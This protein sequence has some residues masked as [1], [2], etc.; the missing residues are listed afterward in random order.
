MGN[1]PRR[2]YIF[3]RPVQEDDA[4]SNGSQPD[5]TDAP[6]LWEDQPQYNS[7]DYPENY[8][9]QG[10]GLL[11]MLLRG[12]QQDR[13]QPTVDSRLASNFVPEINSD[14][15]GNPQSDSIGRLAAMQAK[16][17]PAQPSIARDQLPLS[18]PR[19]PNFRQL[20]RAPLAIGAP[21]MSGGGLGAYGEKP[22]ASIATVPTIKTAQLVLPGGRLPFPSI[23][24]SPP[25]PIPMPPIPFAWKVIGGVA[26]MLPRVA[27]GLAGRG[28]DGGTAGSPGGATILDQRKSPGSGSRK[29]G[30][31]SS[32]DDDDEPE[33]DPDKAIED[34]RKRIAAAA[35]ERGK[36][37]S[38]NRNRTGY[39][40]RDYCDDRLEDEMRECYK[41]WSQGEMAEESFLNACIEFAR[42]RRNKC[43][44]GDLDPEGFD[45]WNL[46]REEVYNRDF[47][48][49][50]PSSD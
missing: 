41:R 46:E 28:D 47:L 35:R 27:S 15:F 45:E 18:D 7:S 5:T 40:L 4:D 20:S 36:A 25:H 34:N 32:R 16:P 44:K 1:N 24:S 13:D 10:G 14:S 39:D 3:R 37:F 2:I 26:H 8:L 31:S 38:G 17:I 30:A 9:D 6:R 33:F 42:E 19:N 12:M 29:N 48:S 21:Q 43:R 50:K 49:R 11:G 23:G 22:L